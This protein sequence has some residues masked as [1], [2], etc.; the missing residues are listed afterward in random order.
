MDSSDAG[1]TSL[2][3]TAPGERD[4]GEDGARFLRDVMWV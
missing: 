1:V 3:E 4:A 2:C